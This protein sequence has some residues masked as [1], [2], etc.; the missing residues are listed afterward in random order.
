[1]NSTGYIGM[2]VYENTIDLTTHAIA[3]STTV[4]QDEATDSI[5]Q[6]DVM[7]EAAKASQFL[8]IN[9]AE[10]LVGQIP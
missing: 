2:C 6:F 10:Q 1:M 7:A 5:E 9:L 8:D 4:M 3:Y